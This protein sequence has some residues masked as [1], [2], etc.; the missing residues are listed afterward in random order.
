MTARPAPALDALEDLL[1]AERGVIRNG[2]LEG[3]SRMADLKEAL[4]RDVAATPDLPRAQLDR[5]RMKADRN[6]QLLQAAAQ[7][8]RAAMRRLD[9]IRRAQKPLNTYGPN[10]LR[11]PLAGQRGGS[12]EKRA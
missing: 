8:V 4:L 2:D 10:G 7:G 6:Q 9:A 12:V 3:I 1:D 5:L 11:E